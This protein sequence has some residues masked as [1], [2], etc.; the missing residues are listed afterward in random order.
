MTGDRVADASEEAG[1]DIAYPVETFVEI[2]GSNLSS[3]EREARMAVGDNENAG[4]VLGHYSTT[5]CC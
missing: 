1:F 5:S 2:I 3:S 4:R